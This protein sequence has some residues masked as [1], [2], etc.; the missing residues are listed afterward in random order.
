[1]R[2]ILFIIRKEFLQ[3]FRNKGMLPII[4][5]LPFLQ[6]LILSHAADFEIQNLKVFYIDKDQSSASRLLLNK[7]EGSDYFIISGYG[8]NTAEGEV[9]LLADDSDLVIEIPAGFERDLV[10]EGTQKIQLIINAIDGTKAGLGNYYANAVI[11][12]YN[13]EIMQ[14]YGT[15]K[16]VALMNFKKIEVHYSNWF[17]PSLN[18]KTFMVPGILVLLITMIGAFL[19]SMNIVREKEMGTIEQINVTPIKKYQFIIGKLFPFWVIGIVELTIGL[20]LAKLIFEVPFLG[21]LVTIYGFSTIYLLLILGMGLLI[22]TLTDTQQQAMFI[23]WFFLVIFILMSGLFTPIENMP[24]WAQKITLLNP[25]RYFIEVV[26][27]VMLKGSGF[28]DI[29]THLGIVSFYAIV[30]NALAAL[31]YRKTV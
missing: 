25:I 12:D 10:R 8:F 19:S 14:R 15:A 16:Q 21:S 20:V 23:S 7:L 9:S 4:L 30:L 22:S 29:T 27:M 28:A 5:V 13:S 17:N 2:T 1:M 6:L 24:V 26:R 31:R 3:I 18:Y 11:Q